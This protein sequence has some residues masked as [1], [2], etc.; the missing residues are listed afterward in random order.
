MSYKNYNWEVV[1]DDFNSPFFR[2]YIWVKGLY[3][4]PKMN[5]VSRLVCGIAYENGNIKYLADMANWGKVHEEL[6]NNALAD[7]NFFEYL[8]DTSHKEGEEFNKWSEANIF[9]L[10]LSEKSGK[11]LVDLLEKFSDWQGKIYAL[12]TALPVLDFQSFSYVEGFLKDYLNKNVESKE[13]SKYYNLFTQPPYNSFAQDQEEDLL[14]MMLKYWDNK[15]WQEDTKNKSISDIKEAYP[16]FYQELEKHTQK[17]TW[18]YYAYNG[19]ESNESIFLN[20]IKDY[21]VKKEDPQEVLDRMKQK[22]IDISKQKAEFIKKYKPTGREKK[23][24]E[25]AGKFVWGKPRRKDY[26]SKSYFHAKKLQQEIAKRLNLS[27]EQMKHTPFEMIKAGLIDGQEVDL[28]VINSIKKFH[29]ILPNDD[30][31]IEIFYGKEA[32]DFYEKVKKP[33]EDLE[34]VSE[35]HGTTAC[36]GIAKGTA[37]IVN[38]ASDMPKM[39]YGDI[40]VSVSTT[41]NIVAAMKKASAIITDEGG[42]TCH[43]AIVSRELD[44]PCVVGL[45][46]VSKILKDGDMVEV[47]ADNGII[48]KLNK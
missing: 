19:P 1:A 13:V 4:Y 16:E 37:K 48:K 20:F 5:N 43:A 10:D 35:F 34:N 2:N 25:I 15:K 18:V 46:N 36:P 45:K 33:E 12:G 14:N 38:D 7:D 39:E 11:E 28:K 24:L 30:N 40:L 3:Y 31:S 42:L 17:H 21:I 27:L 32:D 47:D 41:P 44:T 8:I 22:K 29:I 9:E 23:M 6:K 26:Q